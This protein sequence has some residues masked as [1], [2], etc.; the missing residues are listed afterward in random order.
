MDLARI[1]EELRNQKLDGWLFFDHHLRDPLAYRVAR[2]ARDRRPVAALV[3]H[4]SRGGR[5]AS[6]W[7]TASSA[8]SSAP[9]PA[10]R[11]RIPPGRSSA[12]RSRGSSPGKK[13][14]AMQ[15]SPDVRGAVCLQRGRRHHRAGAQ[16]GSGSG[17]FGRADPGLRS[18]L[19][20]V[21]D[22]IALRSGP[23][24]RQG[25]RRRLR[26]D[27]RAHA[28]RRRRC[29][30]WRCS[31]SCATGSRRRACSPTTAR[32]WAATRTP[33]TRTTSRARA[34]PRRSSRA[35]GC[36][37]ICGPSSISPTRC[38]TT[39]R[40]RRSAAT[41]PPTRCAM[42]S[43]SSPARAMR[44]SSACR[45]DR[46]RHEP[47]HGFEVDDA[48]RAVI[49][50]RGLRRILHAPHRPLD[51]RGGARQRRQHGQLRNP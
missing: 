5:A 24:R 11:S 21:A 42:C 51:R 50:K 15:Y 31:N 39:S 13:R 8:S 35:T 19:D 1:Q 3:L 7:S 34:S 30:K 27:S 46:G 6:A 22:G 41:I 32:S 17:H 9:C 26:V 2:H 12:Q 23:A 28:Q 25:A 14:I 10:R 37:S 4:D 48:C 44:P 29:R 47:L 20:A 43:A 40:G 49:H 33:R 16:P 18:A 36:C 45:G 38:T